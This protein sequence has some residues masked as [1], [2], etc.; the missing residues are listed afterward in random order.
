MA[1]GCFFGAE[2]L[3]KIFSARREGL[4]PV[5]APRGF[6]FATMGAAAL[7][8][9]ATLFFPVAKAT[10]VKKDAVRIA[11]ADLARRV[12][13]EPWKIR[14]LD[15]RAE[16]SCAA[17]RVPGAE[18]A[19][20]ATLGDLGLAY[21]P[22]ARDLVLVASAGNLKKVPRAALGFTGDIYILEGG[23]KAWTAY[24]LKPPAPPAAEAGA[25]QLEAF[26]VQSAI[27][28]LLTGARAAPPPPRKAVKYEPKKRRKTG[29]CG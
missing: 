8:A 29:G 23:F 3:E 5:R 13:E 6:A 1:I 22:P 11:P 19:P 15:L 2:K 14:I 18:C 10:A 4:E 20:L 7:V 25:E 16:K 12:V 28:R 24:A 27:H 21:S 17:Q 26:R 9:V